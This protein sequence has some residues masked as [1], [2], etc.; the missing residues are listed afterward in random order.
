M[1][2]ASATLSSEH[3]AEVIVCIRRY[4]KGRRCWI[5]G[6]RVHHGATGA[7]IVIASMQV[8]G[9]ARS[10]GIIVGLLLCAHDRRDW[11][12]WFSREGLPA[13]AA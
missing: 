4:P 12:V 11:R 8:H 2:R 6:Q 7:A 3:G 5:G 1:I 9:R 10:A 13:L